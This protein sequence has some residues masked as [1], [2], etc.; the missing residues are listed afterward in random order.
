MHRPHLHPVTS[1]AL[2]L[3]LGSVP[4][5]AR[6]APSFPILTRAQWTRQQSLQPA[7]AAQART[8]LLAQKSQL[9]LGGRDSL[10]V[11]SA[12]T[13]NQGQAIVR[14][15][16]TFDGF[17]V[18]GTQAIAHVLPD[19][20]MRTL[21]R[22]LQAGIDLQGAPR[23]SGQQAAQAAL[24]NLAP[25]GAA[26][27]APRIER[28]VFPAQFL[29]GLASMTD[30]KT[31][32]QVL[33][34]KRSIH[35]KLA[36]PFAWAYEVRIHL[37]NR[38][39]GVQD[40]VYVVDANTGNILRVNDLTQHLAGAT[41]A[42]G[43]GNGFYR[44]AVTLDTS[45]MADGTY[46]LYDTTRGTL[47]NP[48]LQYY[49]PD[50]SGWSA[51]GMQVWYG[52]NDASGHPTWNSYLFQSN[53]ANTWGD[54]LAWGPSWGQ[55]SGPNGQTAGVDAMSAMATSWD[56]FTNVFGR[57]GLDGLGTTPF[58]QVLDT[59]DV[60]PD[61]TYWSVG[62]FGMYLSPGTYPANPKGH[63][64]MTDLDIVAHEMTHGVTSPGWS[65]Y[66]VSGAGYE[67]SGIDEATSDFFAQMVKA[68]A[69]RPAGADSAIPATGADWEIGAGVNRGTPIRWM[70]QP[71]KD[72]RSVDGWHDGIQYMDGHYSAGPMN[73]A[74]YFL[75]QGAS[76]IQGDPHYS[77]F[78]PGG[79]AGIGNDSAARIWFK[80]V[81]EDLLPDGTGSLTFAD[82]RAAAITAADDL[83]GA[84]SPEE[85]AVES[86]FA[87]A[88]VGEAPGQPPRV[89]VRFA[90]WRNGDY[91][92]T[93]HYA[94]YGNRQIFP[95]G[96]T[97]VPRVSVENAP[98]TAVSWTTGGPS[99]FNGG[100]ASG[101]S[102]G[103]INPDGSWTTPR[104]LGWFSITATSHA[105]SNQLAE[106]RVFLINMDTD[107]DLE[108]DATDMA[109]IAY[110]WYLSNGLNPAHS[111]FEA[112]WVDDADV[113]FFVDAMRSTWPVK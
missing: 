23:L 39:D 101:D 52:E 59:G 77:P 54:G 89:L 35:A 96:E 19:G 78:L 104:E 64:S 17:R 49:T 73:R 43:T 68:Y 18:W 10:V 3:V 15:N 8:R 58:A 12:F 110:S 66:W 98:D 63:L 60:F 48:Q 85:G 31:G 79:M 80:A 109:G 81:T 51:T 44:G 6:T 20:G 65:Q 24:R 45:Q 1:L 94:D 13:N 25:K 33:D 14:L 67:E 105:D 53:P 69:T 46:A 99:M 113:S 16:Q 27:S 28:V 92:Q 7:R 22:D 30:P 103:V 55:E 5:S 102:G 56:F 61:G 91:L 2:A 32:R 74:L 95:N 112:P 37:Q 40:L 57:N 29:G 82:A 9:G 93:T 41:P 84:G 76:S 90:D 62:G 107:M 111:V 72:Q 42:Q 36:S 108:Q 34:R 75:S 100:E 47:P 11:Q 71:D 97:L 70:D 87:A 38:Q 50:G 106:G 4:G 21:T 83:F 86:A 26:P 88:N